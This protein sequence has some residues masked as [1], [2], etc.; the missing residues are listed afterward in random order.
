MKERKAGESGPRPFHGYYFHILK[1]QGASAP[2]GKFDYVINGN[3]VAGH[4]MVAYPAKWGVSGVMT[5]IVNHR[6]RVYQKNLG[7]DTGVIARSMES[8]DPD[9]SWKLVEQ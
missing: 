1:K 3:M 8:Y 9:Q 4:A 2:G 6:G 7:P 5:F